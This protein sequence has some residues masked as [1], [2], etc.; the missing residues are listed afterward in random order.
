MSVSGGGIADGTTVTAIV[1]ATSI[2]VLKATRS[3]AGPD[4]IEFE[5]FP[6]EHS[7]IIPGLYISS[8]NRYVSIPAGTYV[9]NVGLVKSNKSKKLVEMMQIETSGG[10]YDWSSIEK[11][12]VTFS[13]YIVAISSSATAAISGDVTFYQY[14][15]IIHLSAAATSTT[16]TASVTFY[17]GVINLT[18][19][20][21]NFT[22]LTDR[23]EIDA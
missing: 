21:T 10:L 20:S 22:A 1:V 8:P 17:G 14:S 7:K 9:K 15:K 11:A 5:Y 23:I 6:T 12:N 19:T 3:T 18:S 13:K 16:S 4:I 2:S